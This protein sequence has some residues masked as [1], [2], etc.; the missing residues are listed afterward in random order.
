MDAGTTN[1][2]EG[3]VFPMTDDLRALLATLRVQGQELLPRA[4]GI[5]DV[6]YRG[7]ARGEVTAVVELSGA[8][9]HGP[10]RRTFRVRL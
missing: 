4:T 7:G 10:L 5:V 1:N 3:R 8:T 2:R 6:R 9:G